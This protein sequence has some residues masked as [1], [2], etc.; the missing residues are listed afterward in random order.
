MLIKGYSHLSESKAP[1]FPRTLRLQSVRQFLGGF[2]MKVWRT[3]A[4]CIFTSVDMTYSVTI[5]YNQLL[6]WCSSSLLAILL[7]KK[8][9]SCW[10]FPWIEGVRLIFFIWC[11]EFKLAETSKL[12][13][14]SNLLPLA[15]RG[16][17]S[18]PQS[19]FGHRHGMAIGIKGLKFLL[20]ASQCLSWL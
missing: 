9:T 8:W 16:Q 10:N 5:K 12:Q 20:R 11:K 18:S 7:R 15:Q 6:Q 3:S 14:E 1:I 2:Y 13:G 19:G 4:A 17:L